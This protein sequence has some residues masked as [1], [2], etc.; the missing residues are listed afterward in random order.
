MPLTPRR[1][2]SRNIAVEEALSNAPL[3]Y[4]KTVPYFQLCNG[5]NTYVFPLFGNQ[6][7][8]DEFDS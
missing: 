5:L 7:K 4:M 3:K 6:R 2:N 1:I 8:M